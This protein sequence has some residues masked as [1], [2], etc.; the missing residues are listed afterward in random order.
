MDEQINKQTSMQCDGKET[1][2]LEL[3]A[4]V[5]VRKE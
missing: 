5:A 1:K 2:L 4:L 3:S